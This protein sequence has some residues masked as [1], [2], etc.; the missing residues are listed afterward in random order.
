MEVAGLVIGSFSLAGLF[1]TCVDCFEYL[2]LGRQLGKDYQRSV[3][4]LDLVKL[5]LSR[6]GRSVNDSSSSI[7]V[8]SESEID[9]V[10]ETLGQIIYVFE[11]AERI[12]KR[13]T[14]KAHGGS[15]SSARADL[16]ADLDADIRAVHDR[17][18]SLALDRQK[19]SS[20]T[21]K[22]AWA[23]YEKKHFD[24]LVEDVT[25]LVDTLVKLFPA[26]QARQQ[27]LVVEEVGEIESHAGLEALEEA[28][29]GVDS[30]F[31]ASVKNALAG[32]HRHEFVRNKASGDTRVRY[33][34]E[35]EDGKIARS[36]T[37]SRYEGNKAT[38]KVTVP[39][40]DRYAKG[41]IFS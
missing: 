1:T 8:Q 10:K 11:D 32:Q 37:G 17:L 12:S 26:T 33:G 28:A 4:K 24:R 38:G 39:Y 7:S 34:D 25:P 16:N 14:P 18:K 36:Q 21:Q 40:G 35:V 27:E 15:S 6:W 2:Q 3:L 22:A 41:S 5:R 9:K 30:V 19:R 29:D 13:M 31:Q 20:F 23:L